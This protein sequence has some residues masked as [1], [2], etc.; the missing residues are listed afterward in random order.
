M[1]ASTNNVN[2]L[3]TSKPQLTIIH[4]LN[5]LMTLLRQKLTTTKH[6]INLI[7]FV[8]TNQ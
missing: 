4:H 5:N 3:T 2:V 8:T 1:I 6:F 7:T